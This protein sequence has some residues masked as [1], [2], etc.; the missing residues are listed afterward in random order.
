MRPFKHFVVSTVS[1]VAVYSL[2]GSLSPSIACFL[3]GWVIDVDHFYD[4]V[5]NNGWDFSVKRFVEYFEKS[6]PVPLGTHLYFFFHA[7]EFAIILILICFLSKLNLT[8]SF[9][10]LGYIT[11]LLFDQFTNRVFPFAYFLTYRI[12]KGFD[13][14]SISNTKQLRINKAE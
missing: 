9:A 3:T 7:H 1:G 12:A 10:T 2:T 6:H 5:K 11:H 14:R 8:L 13:K 4:Y